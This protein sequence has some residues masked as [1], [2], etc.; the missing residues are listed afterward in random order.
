MLTESEQ[1]FMDYAKEL[2]PIKVHTQRQDSLWKGPHVDGVTQS[3]LNRFMACPERFRLK[4]VLGWGLKK[5][6]DRNIHY[7][8]MWHI[9]EEMIA[10]KKPWRQ[11]LKDYANRLITAF[12]NQREDVVK[13]YNVCL[14]QFPLY[15]EKWR[16]HKQFEGRK[17]ALSEYVFE[18]IVPVRGSD[19]EEV[20]FGNSFH[21]VKLRGKFDSVD[22]I[23]GNVWL[24]ENKSKGE[25]D[26]F[27]IKRQLTFDL[28]TMMYLSVIRDMIKSKTPPFHKGKFKIAG[29]RYNVIKRPLSGGVGSIK[30]HKP[31]KKNPSGESTEEYFKR[32]H[33]VIKENIDSFFIRWTVD[34]TDEDLDRFEREFL[35][36]I[37]LRLCLWWESIQ[38]NIFDP[39][40]SPSGG[41]NPFHYRCPYGVYN[42]LTE[43][44]STDY[45]VLINEGTTVGLVQ[46][47]SL[48][49]ELQPDAL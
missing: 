45:D 1:S 3:M 29:V 2:G 33:S 26:E 48:F 15:L 34:I 21:P 47:D 22:V 35:H 40:K 16:G 4:Y 13:W 8:N 44:G 41:P 27:Q 10:M 39:W 28:Q 43:G 25:I 37:L 49:P 36:P 5:G 18:Q 9:C 31:T 19:V 24:Q 6:F 20:G 46:M 23:D 32:L 30:Q 11:P 38:N 12:P 14:V 17:P 42:P 7:G